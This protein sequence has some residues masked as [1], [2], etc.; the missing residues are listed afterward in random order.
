MMTAR[1]KYDQMTGD[2]DMFLNVARECS[3]LTLPYLIKNDDDNSQHKTLIT[4]W[5]AVGAKATTNLSSKLMLALLSRWR[6]EERHDQ[7]ARN[8]ERE[9][10]KERKRIRVVDL[11]V[12]WRPRRVRWELRDASK[13]SRGH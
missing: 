13:D 5:Q 11:R 2:R 3:R 4:P 10:Q 12:I 9:N 8:L 7:I 6:A 1:G